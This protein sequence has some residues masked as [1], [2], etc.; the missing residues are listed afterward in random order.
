MTNWASAAKR[1][2]SSMR[3]TTT[4]CCWAAATLTASGTPRAS[5]TAAIR[6]MSSGRRRVRTARRSPHEAASHHTRAHCARFDTAR[7]AAVAWPRRSPSAGSDG[8]ARLG[9]RPGSGHSTRPAALTTPAAPSEIS[10]RLVCCVTVTRSTQTGTRPGSG[11]SRPCPVPAPLAHSRRIRPRHPRRACSRPPPNTWAPRRRTHPR[12]QT[13]SLSCLESLTRASHS[14]A[15]RTSIHSLHC[16]H[17]AHLHAVRSPS[18]P[19]SSHRPPPQPAPNPRAPPLPPARR[20]G[21][22][23]RARSRSAP[24]CRS[25]ERSDATCT[26]RV[27]P[28]PSQ[29]VRHTSLMI[30]SRRKTTPGRWASS[31]SRSNSLRVSWTSVPSTV[32]G[33]WAARCVTGPRRSAVSPRRRRR[34]L[35]RR[36]AG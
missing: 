5:S 28:V 11:S 22:R 1:A 10:S 17:S 15:P 14:S 7:M 27:R 30:C 33:G 13:P 31:A 21:S 24:A 29:L 2:V 26:S 23:R 6:T 18:A 3:S 8:H 32:T 12:P 4:R 20:A 9:Q 36:C 19:P 35:V 34:V 25:L 16:R